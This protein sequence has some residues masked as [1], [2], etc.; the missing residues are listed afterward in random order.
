MREIDSRAAYH[1]IADFVVKQVREALILR[2]GSS[3]IDVNLIDADTSNVSVTKESDL[4]TRTT[5]TA[6]TVK[7][8]HTRLQTHD[9]S[10]KVIMTTHSRINTFTRLGKRTEMESWTPSKLE[11]IGREIIIAAELSVSL[12]RLV[13]VTRTTCSLAIS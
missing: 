9:E 11:V 10:Q 13:G 7:T 12:G 1:E 2:I 8:S 6:T 3:S 4:T 5:S